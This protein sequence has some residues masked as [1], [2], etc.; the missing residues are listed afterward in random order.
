MQSQRLTDQRCDTAQSNKGQS[1]TPNAPNSSRPRPWATPPLRVAG[2]RLPRWATGLTGR[3]PRRARCT[4]EEPW[5]VSAS[6]PGR[7]AP[8]GERRLRCGGADEPAGPLRAPVRLAGSSDGSEPGL[9]REAPAS[10]AAGRASTGRRASAGLRASRPESEELL[11]LRV[12]EL[13]GGWW[14]HISWP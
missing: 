10:G 13:W 1:Q 8:P 12:P 14:F 6:R 11:P 9:L 5:L 3:V 2:P 7:R 4:G